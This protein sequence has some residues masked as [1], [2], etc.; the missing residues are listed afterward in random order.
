MAPLYEPFFCRPP[1]GD[2]WPKDVTIKAPKALTT[3]E[4]NKCMCWGRTTAKA[5][6]CTD[7]NGN[8]A[9]NTR[10]AGADVL[11]GSVVAGCSSLG[12]RWS[13]HS[14]IAAGAA[15][16]FA[17]GAS[18]V[19][20]VVLLHSTTT[21]SSSCIAGFRLWPGRNPLQQV[22]FSSDEDNCKIP[23]IFTLPVS[24][25]SK[26]GPFRFVRKKSVCFCVCWA[27]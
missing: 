21:W 9:R 12:Q 26:N 2:N 3:R 16:L 5:F 11:L 18:A 17:F 7:R 22:H 25:M 19:Q 6:T 24:N 4:L 8:N 20:F 27:K 15:R 10:K 14:A 23:G 13:S 1:Q